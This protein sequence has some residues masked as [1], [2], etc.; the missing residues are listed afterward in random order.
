MLNNEFAIGYNII[1]RLGNVISYQPID[2]ERVNKYYNELKDLVTR[3]EKE[4]VIEMKKAEYA[5]QLIM[6]ANAYRSQ[7][8]EIARSCAKAELFFFDARFDEAI[9]MV[10]ESL[11]KYIDISSFE[12]KHQELEG[13]F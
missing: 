13:A 12:A 3:I 2:V 9:D 6:F 8:A 11:R 10:K 7:F 5:E 4:A 1:E